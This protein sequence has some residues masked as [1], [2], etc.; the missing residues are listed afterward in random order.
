VIFGFHRALLQILVHFSM[1][2]ECDLAKICGY[3]TGPL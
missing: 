2:H 3:G 1:C